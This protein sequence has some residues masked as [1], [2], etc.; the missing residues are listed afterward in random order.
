MRCLLEEH[1]YVTP[2]VRRKEG[3]D[4]RFEAVRPNQLWLLD[5]LHRHINK[6]KVYVLLILDDFS[7]F[8]VG[9]AIWDGELMSAVQETFSKHLHAVG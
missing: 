6:Q 3:H 9:G 1:G 4:Q 7:R 2:R 8:I 5:F